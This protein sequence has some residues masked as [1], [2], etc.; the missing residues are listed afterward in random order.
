METRKTQKSCLCPLE[1]TWLT[2]GCWDSNLV[3]LAEHWALLLSHCSGISNALWYNVLTLLYVAEVNC[4]EATLAS[5]GLSSDPGPWWTMPQG[6]WVT[7]LGWHTDMMQRGSKIRTLGMQPEIQDRIWYP[8]TGSAPLRLHYQ[9]QGV[10]SDFLCWGADLG[11]LWGTPDNTTFKL[12][13]G[14]FCLKKDLKYGQWSCWPSNGAVFL[15]LV[16]R[17][18]LANDFFFLFLET[19]SQLCSLCWPG[20][21]CVDQGL[22][23]IQ[24]L[25]SLPPQCWD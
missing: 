18:P 2:T 5:P 23:L 8:E 17:K 16:L 24:I 14:L 7:Y 11:H 12:A 3:S 10:G 20:T 13:L 9:E 25:L 21:T 15:S 22:D 19:G 4:Y 1:N 6:Q